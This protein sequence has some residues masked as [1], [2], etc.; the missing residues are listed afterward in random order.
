M[1]K[2]KRKFYNKMNKL[3]KVHPNDPENE[4]KLAHNYKKNKRKKII[5][6]YK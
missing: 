3:H 6:K 2:A 1:K 5:N 4:I